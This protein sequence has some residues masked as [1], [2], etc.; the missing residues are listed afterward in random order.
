MLYSRLGRFICTGFIRLAKEF[1]G[2]EEVKTEKKIQTEKQSQAG[3][4]SQAEKEPRCLLCGGA[5]SYRYHCL[6]VRTLPIRDLGGERKVQALGDFVDY[7]VCGDCAGKKLREVQAGMQSALPRLLLF[8]AILAAGAGLALFFH[9]KETAYFFFGL[10]CILGGLLGLIGTV[11]T[12]REKK[13]AYKGK[14]EKEQL[15]LAAWEALT[16]G[17]PK[18]QGDENLTYIPVDSYTLSRKKG[19]LM[20][21]YN[22]LPDIA[23]EA[24]K[25]IHAERDARPR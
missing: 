22:L 12:V 1:E 4:Q 10:I 15:S 17:A 7:A 25:R 23:V 20:V 6:Q 8:A 5:P 9:G 13:E 14:G 24:Y 2:R 16:G 19:D 21:L 3:K 11:Q 18:K